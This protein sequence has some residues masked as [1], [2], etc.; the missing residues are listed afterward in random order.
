MKNIKQFWHREK[1]LII[2]ISLM[3]LGTVCIVFLSWKY[4]SP[5]IVTMGFYLYL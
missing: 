1:F 4:Q 5:E 3:I 2:V